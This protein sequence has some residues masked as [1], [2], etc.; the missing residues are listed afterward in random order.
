MMKYL[1]LLLPLFLVS[2]SSTPEK[3]EQKAEQK[4]E[5]TKQTVEKK[6]EAATEKAAPE[7]KAEPS[8]A[9]TEAAKVVCTLGKDVRN[10]AN[11]KTETGGCEVAYEKNGETNV[12]ATAINEVEHC[13]TVVERI[14]NNLIG[15]GFSCE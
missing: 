10:I 9:P 14:K 8:T 4:A 1:V 2:C 15:A 11:N 13:N 5:E 12:V 6:V 7:T 3:A